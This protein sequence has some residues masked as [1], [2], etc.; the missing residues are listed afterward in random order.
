ME[1]LSE[2]QIRRLY[3]IWFNIWSKTIFRIKL[4]HRIVLL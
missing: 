2:K 3:R 1:N 4:F